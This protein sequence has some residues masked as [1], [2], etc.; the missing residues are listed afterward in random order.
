MKSHTLIAIFILVIF[1]AYGNEPKQA[2]AEDKMIGTVA[3]NTNYKEAA[4]IETFWFFDNL[5]KKN[6]GITLTRFETVSAL[7]YA[8]I[9]EKINPEKPIA[10]HATWDQLLKKY[11]STQGK[12]NYK[13]FKADKAKLETY[14]NELK[15]NQPTSSWSKNKKL[16]YWI[17]VYNAFTVK[18]IVDNY[19]LKSITNLDKPWDTPFI[20]MGSKT[21][22]LNNIEHEIIR[23][24]FNEPRIHFAVNCA[25]LSCPILLNEAYTESKLNSQLD[26]Q[27]RA[28]INNSQ[29]NAISANKVEISA[30]F[31][32]YK[33]DFIKNGSLI[34]F[35]NKYS[36]TKIQSNASVTYKNYNW[37][38]NE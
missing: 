13:G 10:K 20:K 30:I 9:E 38:L 23:K 8:K 1:F 24:Q 33:E 34:D 2:Q 36:K 32:W 7:Q 35:L 14:L 21:Y 12:V 37:N 11:V 22:S 26:K 27:S 28:Y 19:P 3:D 31:D 5:C 4:P 18:L 15:N 25:A 16:A 29:E 6:I 17:N